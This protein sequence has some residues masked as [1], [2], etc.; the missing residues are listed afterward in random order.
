ME[1]SALNLSLIV[2]A[3]FGAGIYGAMIGSTLLIIVP[4]LHFLGM[5]I[6]VAIG[7]GKI[8]VVGR[9][10][11]P[12]IHFWQKNLLSLRS[13]IPFSIAAVLASFFGSMVAVEL[14]GPIL[15]KIV[16]VFMCLISLIILLNPKVGLV[17][18]AIPYTG[19]HKIGNLLSGLLI[20]FYTGLFG[21]GSNVFIIINFIV[22]FGYDFLKASANSKIP[23]LI[24][25]LASLPV[26]IINGY[27]S[28]LVAIPLTIS[29]AA[30][31][32]FGTKLA[33][34]K[35]S[36]FIRLLF[37]GLVLI[38]AFKYLLIGG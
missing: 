9:E 8:S 22:I 30:G 19:R 3:G 16:A 11:I 29:T 26:F 28:W 37:V 36:Q 32:H 13:A 7:T 14:N 15:E 6:Q 35:G 10:I 23:N 24:I 12:S 17:E 27:V 1:I 5:P 31:A 25:T 33:I 21:G 20:G 2:V 4:M 38:I 18:K 34:K